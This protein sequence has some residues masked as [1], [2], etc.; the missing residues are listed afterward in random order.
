M[1]L[2]RGLLSEF[3]VETDVQLHPESSMFDDDGNF[4]FTNETDSGF[5][6][7]LYQTAKTAC[8]R[9]NT[10]NTYDPLVPTQPSKCMAGGAQLREHLHFL[11]RHG[12]F[13]A[14]ERLD[15]EIAHRRKLIEAMGLAAGETFASKIGQVEKHLNGSGFYISSAPSA[16][17]ETPLFEAIKMTCQGTPSSDNT[18]NPTAGTCLRQDGSYGGTREACV[19]TAIGGNTYKIPHPNKCVDSDGQPAGPPASSSSRGEC[20]GVRVGRIYSAAVNSTC[21]NAA[22]EELASGAHVT[23]AWC[24][25]VATSLL[26]LGPRGCRFCNSQRYA[27][28]RQHC[29][30]VHRRQRWT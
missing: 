19:G 27:G 30:A 23:Q 12:T 14:K 1:A 24:E 3:P 21:S 9:K 18:Y 10:N 22:G 4:V 15:F 2:L 28:H 16:D 17:F 20:E 11:T 13:T 25:G 6:Q 26:L 29:V 5:Q 8:E 7:A